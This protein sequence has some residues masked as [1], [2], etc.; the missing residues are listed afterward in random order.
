MIFFN[1]VG[2]WKEKCGGVLRTSDTLNRVR[3]Q[4]PVK[5]TNPWRRMISETREVTV[6]VDLQQTHVPVLSF[7][8]IKT[9]RSSCMYLWFFSQF[10]FLTRWWSYR[11]KFLKIHPVWSWQNFSTPQACLLP[12]WGHFLLLFFF[13][14]SF[15]ACFFPLSRVPTTHMH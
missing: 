5:T 4:G 3:F 9:K 11:V 13:Q 1:S 2:Q 10:C 6:L 8:G 7:D 15:T 14:N 12:S